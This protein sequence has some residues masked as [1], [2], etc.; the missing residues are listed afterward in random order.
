MTTLSWSST[1]TW[2]NEREISHVENFDVS[3]KSEQENLYKD[4]IWKLEWLKNEVILLDNSVGIKDRPRILTKRSDMNRY[5]VDAALLRKSFALTSSQPSHQSWVLLTNIKS[6]KKDHQSNVE[7][8]SYIGVAAS[9]YDPLITTDEQLNEDKEL[10]LLINEMNETDPRH[11]VTMDEYE[12][13]IAFTATTISVQNLDQEDPNSAALIQKQ[14]Q[15]QWFMIGDIVQD[16]IDHV[17]IVRS[18]WKV[19]SSEMNVSYNIPWVDQAFNNFVDANDLEPSYVELFSIRRKSNVEILTEIDQADTHQIKSEWKT[20]EGDMSLKK[21]IKYSA[22]LADKK[23]LKSTKKDEVIKNIV[24]NRKIQA[25]TKITENNYQQG[26]KEPLDKMIENTNNT[27][28]ED[29]NLE[30]TNVTYIDGHHYVIEAPL[31]W[32]ELDASVNFE[33]SQDD[34]QVS[35]DNNILDSYIS[36][37]HPWI[38][39]TYDINDTDT[40]NKCFE[41]QKCLHHMVKCLD[42]TAWSWLTPTQQGVLD[43]L[44]TVIWN[45]NLESLKALNDKLS[46]PDFVETMHRSELDP[47]YE[48]GD[49]AS[50]YAKNMHYFFSNLLLPGQSITD[51]SKLELTSTS[52]INWFDDFHDLTHTP[53]SVPS[54]EDQI[55]I[56]KLYWPHYTLEKN[57]SSSVCYLTTK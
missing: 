32:S 35:L 57:M 39:L 36:S 27:E 15:E 10:V 44:I 40:M 29:E 25:A 23:V 11:E 22:L 8:D 5:N 33:L 53:D 6:Y 49:I 55:K 51:V 28:N 14:M 31:I 45:C 56:N 46:K 12:E 16:Y 30:I 54:E 48:Y 19:D 2:P 34:E 42:L 41:Q 7:E 17:F 37:P 43:S 38:T 3:K 18:I 26:F 13:W 50:W 1:L 52:I 4:N 24:K 47:T 9:L 20:L 21:L